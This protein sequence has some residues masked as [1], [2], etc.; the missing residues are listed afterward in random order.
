[1]PLV[2]MHMYPGRTAEQKAGVVRGITEAVARELGVPASSVE[3]LLIEVPR[4]HW[5]FGGTLASQQSPVSST[6]G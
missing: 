4:E 1:M 6:S 2:T 5:G 3:V